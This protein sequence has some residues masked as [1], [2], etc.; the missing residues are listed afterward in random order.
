MCPT[1]IRDDSTALPRRF[2]DL[3]D[4]VR[5]KAQPDM[6]TSD[7]MN[8]RNFLKL[9]TG[10]L[11]IFGVPFLPGATPSDCRITPGATAGPFYPSRDRADEEVDLTHIEGRSDTAQGKKIRLHGRVLD[12]ACEPVEGATIEIWQADTN[13]RY[14]HE[15]DNRSVPVDPAFQGWGEAKSDADGR[16]GFKTVKPAPYPT[17]AE[18]SDMRAPHIHVR[19]VS[20]EHHELITQMFFEGEPLNETDGVIQDLSAQDQER[21]IVAPTSEVGVEEDVYALDLT[22][23]T[24]QTDLVSPELLEQYAGTYELEVGGETRAIQ[25]LHEGRRLYGNGPFVSRK[26]ELRPLS[27]TRFDTGGFVGD[28]IRFPSGQEP[29]GRLTLVLGDREIPGRKVE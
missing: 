21:L 2:A 28:V 6:S 10:G 25:I 17:G 27:E 20:P 19:A 26:L 7:D 22:L 12:E 29:G 23:P 24:L 3:I 15:R 4:S 5:P 11:A 18:G 8:R 1:S 16:Y 13:G 14:R 9:G